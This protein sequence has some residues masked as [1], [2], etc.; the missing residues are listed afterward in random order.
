MLFERPEQSDASITSGS[1]SQFPFLLLLPLVLLLCLPLARSLVGKRRRALAGASRSAKQRISN[2]HSGLHGVTEAAKRRLDK[3]DEMVLQFSDD[4]VLQ[5]RGELPAGWL[6]HADKL[7]WPYYVHAATG[8]S[9]LEWPTAAE[10]A[11]ALA[12]CEEVLLQ[13][14][15]DTEAL[16]PVVP[17]AAGGDLVEEIISRAQRYDSLVAVGRRQRQTTLSQTLS[18]LADGGGVNEAVVAAQHAAEE[19]QAAARLKNAT[20]PDHF[21]PEEVAALCS[22]VS[23]LLQADVEAGRLLD[24]PKWIEVGRLLPLTPATLAASATG[25]LLLAEYLRAVDPESLD[26]RALN[27]AGQGYRGIVN[28][29]PWQCMAQLGFCTATSKAAN[30]TVFDHPGTSRASS[31]CRTTRSSSTH[32]RQQVVVCPICSRR[33]SMRRRPTRRCCSCRQPQPQPVVGL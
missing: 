2:N 5:Q 16:P 14:G 18:F 28:V 26:Q 32:S 7:Q 1:D 33:S 30:L 4:E 19:A 3:I 9:Q 22:H 6:E 20:A 29:A 15:I 12:R 11:S 10:G 27:Y 24:D 31:A 23:S 21:S 17:S 25:S 13:Q 8:L